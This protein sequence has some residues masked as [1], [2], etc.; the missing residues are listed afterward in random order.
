MSES[1]PEPLP[2]AESASPVLTSGLPFAFAQSR[3]VLLERSGAA[4]TLQSTTDVVDLQAGGDLDATATG[5]VAVSA[6]GTKGL[7]L[8][9]ASQGTESEAGDIKLAGAAGSSVSMASGTAGQVSLAT[10]GGTLSLST[11]GQDDQPSDAG[12]VVVSGGDLTATAGSVA[13]AA[14]SATGIVLETAGTDDTGAGSLV[15]KTV[16]EHYCNHL[17]MQVSVFRCLSRQ[18]KRKLTR[19]V[20]LVLI[21]SSYIRVAI[22]MMKPTVTKV[23]RRQINQYIKRKFQSI[24][25]KSMMKFL[26]RQQK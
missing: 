17:K 14:T 21:L 6:R 23:K 16:W 22:A 24:I 20:L 4:L 2:V 13:I 3:N 11:A 7:T 1:A 15:M 8:S 5:R 25:E 26:Y 18:A 12:D 19:R 9:T 10:Q